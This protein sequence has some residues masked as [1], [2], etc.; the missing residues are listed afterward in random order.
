MNK[1]R[2]QCPKC[3]SYNCVLIEEKI[4]QFITF[5]DKKGFLKK[6]K[7]NAGFIDNHLYYITCYDCKHR[8]EGLYDHSFEIE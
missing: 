5:T 7:I 3:K 8:S 4:F 6:K 1:M 2:L